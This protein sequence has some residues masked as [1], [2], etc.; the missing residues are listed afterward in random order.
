MLILTGTA[1]CNFLFYGVKKNI[2][3]HTNSIIFARQKTSL[4]GS[5]SMVSGSSGSGVIKPIYRRNI[6]V[7]ASQQEP[8]GPKHLKLLFTGLTKQPCV[9]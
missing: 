5:V 3:K 6:I 9:Q 4:K 8:P 1:R 7:W 2:F